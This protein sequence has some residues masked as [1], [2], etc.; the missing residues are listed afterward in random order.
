MII[1][2]GIKKGV[3]KII[4]NASAHTSVIKNNNPTIKSIMSYKFN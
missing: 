3:I 2:K 4:I 1:N